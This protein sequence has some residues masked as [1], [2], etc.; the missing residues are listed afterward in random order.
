MVA[1]NTQAFEIDVKTRPGNIVRVDVYLPA[2][3]TV[4]AQRQGPETATGRKQLIIA[5]VTTDICL[6]FPA[7]CALEADY[8]VQVVLDASGS[9]FAIGE[10]T[11][12]RRMER[13]GVW[14]TSTNTMLAEL[15]GN[16]ATPQGMALVPLLAADPPMLPVY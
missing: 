7:I 8:E 9:S 13:A 2:G 3:R 10:E 1:G 6:V 4:R 16:W 5:A 12:L 15:V 11:S 14:L